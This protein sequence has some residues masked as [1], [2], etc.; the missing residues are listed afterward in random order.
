MG[1]EFLLNTS[2]IGSQFAPKLASLSDGGFV[3]VWVDFDANAIRGQV[4]DA[5]GA[6]KGGEF[7]TDTVGFLFNFS[8]DR[9]HFSVAGLADGRFVV[10]WHGSAVPDS[11]IT[12][13]IFDPRDGVV[14]GSTNAET[15]YG[16]DLVN[17]EIGGYL[18]ADTLNGLGGNDWLDGGGNAD[19]LDGGTGA[20]TMIGGFG[21]DAYF[22]DNAGDTII[23]AAGQG[24]DNANASVSYTLGV[25]ESVETLQTT[26]AAATTAI[27]LT[28]NN[29]ANTVIGN[30]G[31]NA[32][33]GGGEA[34]SLNGLGGNDTYALGAEND[35]VNDSGGTDTI[36][37]TITRSLVAFATIENLTLLGTAIG[38]IGNGVANILTGNAGANVLDGGG[39]ADS[40]RGLGG[41]D[42]Y[43]VDKAADTIVESTGTDNARASVSYTLRA[44]VTVDAANDQCR[45]ND[46]HPPDRQQPR[47]HRDRQ[48][49]RQRDQRWIGQRQANRQRRQ[50]LLRI[51]HGA[52]RGDQ[53]RHHHRLQGGQ[54]HH[55]AG[56]FDLHRAGSRKAQRGCLPHR[57]GSGRCRGPRHLQQRNRRAVVRFERH[58]RRR[59]D[60]VCP[61]QGRSR[62]HQCG[63]RDCVRPH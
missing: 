58:R 59:P 45:R 18:G 52:Q 24:T 9:E 55:P 37:S 56:K 53:C 35:A 57:R 13:Q 46:R 20:D 29:I 47:Q 26:N 6:R 12:S 1:A 32:L 28:G 38:G 30:A 63:L 34:D 39:G 14:N 41:N 15:L 5:F 43:F 62:T 44:G 16:H 60:Q 22:V 3:A 23:E 49:R 40:L 10:T 17:D 25:N 4:F 21:D 31:D 33:D 11:A 50:R 54:R 48:R 8:D 27:N 7:S 61:A 36:T 51:Q 2:T 19:T 42:S